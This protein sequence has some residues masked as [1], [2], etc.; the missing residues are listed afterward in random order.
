M[1]TQRRKSHEERPAAMGD[2]VIDPA[3]QS[4]VDQGGDTLRGLWRVQ[5]LEL[6]PVPKGQEGKFYEGD[7]YLHFDKNPNEQH[8]HFWIGGECS[9]DEQAV[10]AIKAVELDNLFGGLPIQHREVQ[11]FESKRFK[12][13]FPDGMMIKKGGMESGLA[14][15]ETNAH[16]AKLFKV[17]GGMRPVMTEVTMAWSSMN[18]GDVFVLDSGKKIFVWKGS[19]AS[20]QEKMQAGL[21]A[22]KMGDHMGEEIVHVEDGEEE[23][24]CDEEWTEHLP[25]DGRAEI[26]DKDAAHD[27]AVTTEVA[28]SIDLFKVSDVTGEMK[29]EQVKEGNLTKDDLDPNDAFLVSAGALGIWVWLGRKATKGERQSAMQLGEKFIRENGLPPQTA[30]T[31][32][33]QNGEPEEF[34]SLFA[35]GW[36]IKASTQISICHCELLFWESNQNFRQGHKLMS[37]L[38]R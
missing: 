15:A 20:G 30:L 37:S 18:H 21:I 16:D 6:V 35:S 4:L 29:T 2:A 22:A 38:Y 12:D 28:K 36:W 10:A 8:V 9:V 26:K 23:A 25:L 27:K 5:K 33:F 13:Q 17:A 32:T 11:G 7:C 31:R 3:F 1:G 14:K 34:K 24:E 19:A